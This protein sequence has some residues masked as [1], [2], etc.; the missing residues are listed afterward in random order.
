MPAFLLPLGINCKKAMYLQKLSFRENE[1]EKIERLIDG[2]T[3]GKINLIVG[4]NSSGKTRTLNAI[5]ELVELFLGSRALP[6]THGRYHVVFREE[7]REMIYT[8]TYKDGS[9]GEESL[10][11][12]GE[13]VMHRGEEGKGT[14]K[15]MATPKTMFLDFGI[16]KNQLACFAKQDK[17]QHPFLDQLRQWAVNMRRFDFSGNL[18][19]ESYTMK[20]VFEPGEI[21]FRDTRA[22]LVPVLYMGLEQHEGF[23]E[24]LLKDMH[25]I[26]YDLEDLGIMHFSERY[27]PTG[28]DRYAVYTTEAGLEKKVSQRDMS[29]GMF[30]A[31]AVLVHLEY[32]IASGLT[33]CVVID[34]IGEGLDFSRAKWL[35]NL[36]VERA[37]VSGMQLILSTNDAFIMNAVDIRHWAVLNREGN[38]ISLYNYENSKE[39]FEDFKFTGLNNFDFYASEFFK[40]GLSDPS[41]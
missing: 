38:K 8:L 40:S 28:K 25:E 29:Q 33:G 35:V 6:K 26:G 41:E 7:D 2:V 31:F 30:R 36:L 4:K 19:K 39:I 5:S 12:D 18:G 3:M 9:I 21:D 27:E 10:E 34:D 14:I 23:R 15:Y 16:E 22:S 20:A 1:G 17:L 37:E 13:K 32:Y 11:W 24:Q